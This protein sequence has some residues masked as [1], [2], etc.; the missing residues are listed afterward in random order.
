M[1]E[2]LRVLVIEDEDIIRK[3]LVMTTDWKA[4]GLV[5]IG[6][7]D[8]GIDGEELARKL[9]PDIIVTDIAMPGQDGLSL[10][11]NLVEELLDSEFIIISGHAQFSYAQQALH[12][13]V[14]GYILK[15]IDPREFAT[16]L[17]KS[18]EEIRARAG[19]RGGDEL[20]ELKELSASFPQSG[21]DYRDQYIQSAVKTI[22]AHYAEA[23]NVADLAEHMGISERTLSALF[24][25][26]T[27]YTFLEYLTLYRMQNAARL[28]QQK[29]IQVQEVAPEVGYKDYRYFCRVFK[30]CFGVTPLQYKRGE[31]P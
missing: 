12:Y 21:R 18:A 24:K 22:E 9:R 14:K 11:G 6:E 13:G 29:E 19:R 1:E 15:P 10:I 23:L 26:K 31:T 7:A 2:R 27:G 17:S 5:V 30:G 3:G 28:L 20:L 25:E 4:L 16:V 8:N